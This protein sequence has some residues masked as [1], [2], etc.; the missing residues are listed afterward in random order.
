ML[1]KQIFT[2]NRKTNRSTW[3]SCPNVVTFYIYNSKHYKSYCSFHSQ[4]IIF[5]FFWWCQSYVAHLIWDSGCSKKISSHLYVDVTFDVVLLWQPVIE[6]YLFFSSL[7]YNFCF[8]F[9]Y[10][11][12]INPFPLLLF[13]FSCLQQTVSGCTKK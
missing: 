9:G 4:W 8:S 7:D 12:W 6:A 3:C 13:Q 11:W 10:L 5:W 1:C 2:M